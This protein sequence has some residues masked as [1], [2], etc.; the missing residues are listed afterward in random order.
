MTDILPRERALQ[1]SG[2]I[3][4]LQQE[5]WDLW[6]EEE[7]ENTEPFNI[8]ELL[9]TEVKLRETAQ[10]EV[11]L[12][13]KLAIYQKQPTTDGSSAPTEIIQG[14]RAEV[15]MLNE[16]YWMLERKWWSIKGYGDHTQSGI[17]IACYA[18][19]VPGGEDAV[20]GTA[21]AV[22]IAIYQNGSSQPVIALWNVTVVRKLVDLS[23]APSKRRELRRCSILVL[24]GGI[25]KGSGMPRC[26]GSYTL[27]STILLILLRILRQASQTQAS[28]TELLF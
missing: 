1:E 25:S 16:K 8:H 2:Q 24:T 28:I 14:L 17:C 9:R 22:S 15:T 6:R 27:T 18:K 23:S 11:A 7:S 19:I 21:G 3:N 12:K 13:E 10:R 5:R 20:A 26:W 4:T